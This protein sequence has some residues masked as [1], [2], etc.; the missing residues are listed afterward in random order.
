MSGQ[1]LADLLR[2]MADMAEQR[3]ATQAI[4]I[5]PRARPS[6]A[7]KAL[8]LLRPGKKRTDVPNE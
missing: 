1:E 8:D 4:N 5:T 3:A 7:D 2:R 6:E